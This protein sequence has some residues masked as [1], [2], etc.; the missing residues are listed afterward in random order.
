MTN[1]ERYQLRCAVYTFLI[2][3]NKLL[4][5]RRK[6]TGWNDGD[7]GVP[8][9]HVEE[10]ETVSDAA[11]RELY[12]EAGVTAKKTDLHFVHTMHRRSNYDYID[13]FFEVTKWNGTPSLHEPEKS[14]DLQWFKIDKLPENMLEQV[15][16][17]FENYQK[18]IL[19]SEIG[20]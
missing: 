12:E 10:N 11:L 8:A 14:D 4:L 15:K 7:Y 17:G 6:N 9:G 16:L 20:F 18:K 13:L 2:Q 3:D 1:E 5:L 19:F